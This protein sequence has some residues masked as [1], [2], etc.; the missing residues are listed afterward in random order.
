MD[1]ISIRDCRVSQQCGNEK[2][3]NASKS[4]VGLCPANGE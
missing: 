2:L 4:G 3:V 1:R